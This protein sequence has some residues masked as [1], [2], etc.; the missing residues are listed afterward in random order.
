MNGVRKFRYKKIIQ[1]QQ[2]ILWVLYRQISTL[3]SDVRF[4]SLE[5]EI[6]FQTRKIPPFNFPDR[7]FSIDESVW[8]KSIN[9]AKNLAIS[10]VIWHWAT[11]VT[12]T[13]LDYPG[14]G[15]FHI[16][17]WP[18]SFV[19]LSVEIAEGFQR[20]HKP[21][22]PGRS[23][24]KRTENGDHGLPDLLHLWWIFGVGVHVVSDG[25]WYLLPRDTE[26]KGGVP[27]VWGGDG[28]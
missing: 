6:W 15:G 25:S 19:A 9:W 16:Y 18:V 14:V 1:N 28:G 3:D 27:G 8:I 23:L 17:I 10:A 11:L 20:P 12:P 5:S 21:L 22:W 4:W 7:H 24:Y 2:V 26:S 13:E